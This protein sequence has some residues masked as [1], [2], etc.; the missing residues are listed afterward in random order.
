LAHEDAVK[1]L[2]L[3]KEIDYIIESKLCQDASGSGSSEDSIEHHNLNY[4]DE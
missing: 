3:K 4:S 2:Q 1:T